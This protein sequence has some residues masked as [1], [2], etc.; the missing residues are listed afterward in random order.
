MS[1]PSSGQLTFSDLQN[2]YGGTNPIG[3][4]EYYAGGSFVAS[5]TGGNSGLIPSS[6]A[7]PLGRFYGS[8]AAGILWGSRFLRPGATTWTSKLRFINNRFFIFHNSSYGT[9]ITYSTDSTGTNWLT[10]GIPRIA[11]STID[12]I[13]YDIEWTGSLYVALGSNL[14]SVNNSIITSPDL[15]NWTPRSVSTGNAYSIAWNGNI[16]VTTTATAGQLLT[17]PDGITW[18][19]RSTGAPNSFNQVI[20]NGFVFVAVGG[21]SSTYYSTDGITWQA[22]NGYGT[23]VLYNVA[24]GNN[25]F[26]ATTASGSYVYTSPNGVTWTKR[27]HTYI[28]QGGQIAYGSGLFVQINIG[29]SE[30]V[31]SPDGITWT[32]RSFIGTQTGGFSGSGLSDPQLIK[33]IGFGAGKFF[34][35]GK[36]LV[37]SSAD[38]LNWT[39]VSTGAVP[40]QNLKS[41]ATNG[42]TIVAVGEGGRNT[43]NRLTNKPTLMT[44]SDG[45]T[46]NHINTNALT[47][48]SPNLNDVIWTG[49]RFVAVG[50]SASI[51][52]SEDG[53]SWT[54]RIDTNTNSRLI[55]VAQQGNCLIAVSDTSTQEW[56]SND[57]GLTWTLRTNSYGYGIASSN[58][59][60]IKI[61]NTG[62][63]SGIYVTPSLD[64]GATWSTATIIPSTGF[65][66]VSNVRWVN[67]RF[68]ICGKIRSPSGPFM[69][70][71]LDGVTWSNCVAPD[72]VITNGISTFYDVSYSFGKYYAVSNKGLFVSTDGI[73]FS[74]LSGYS[75]TAGSGFAP[76]FGI[77]NT[78]NKI[79]AVGGSGTIV[80]SPPPSTTT[81]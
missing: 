36:G 53:T 27:T 46:W 9:S 28:G 74:L 40:N 55:A 61:T 73:N 14:Y 38:G 6:G 77:K 15:I 72:A 49:T 66:D 19:T 64:G 76:L 44:S 69:L 51:W 57:G 60:F 63:V 75:Y 16:L 12:P 22:G 35:A 67:N 7:L 34:A 26:A 23:D 45:N 17:S 39:S 29:S 47:T 37:V 8:A 52:T 31:T 5:G 41:L 65:R 1:I 11:G 24:W 48:F 56:I 58:S 18:T 20:W 33:S 21:I 80:T 2:E 10:V 4:G 81:L 50:G 70:Y 78:S 79:I 25:T 30:V 62:T 68:I 3:L 32:Y 43:F 71:S 42:T 13:L 54:P 59:V